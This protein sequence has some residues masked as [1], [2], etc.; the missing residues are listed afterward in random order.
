MVYASLIMYLGGGIWSVSRFGRFTPRTDWSDQGYVPSSRLGSSCEKFP[1]F[2]G[3]ETS[4]FPLSFFCYSRPCLYRECRRM[5]SLH[6]LIKMNIS[7]LEDMIIPQA[8]AYRGGG[9]GVQP[10]PPPKFRS[11][12]KAAF[13]CKLSGKCLVFLFQHPN[14]F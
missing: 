3:I 13:D 7:I 9:L 6:F 1:Y 5:T 8:V 2:D 11:F 14:Q 12:D 10:P 4:V